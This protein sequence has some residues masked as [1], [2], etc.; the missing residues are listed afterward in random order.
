MAEFVGYLLVAAGGALGSVARYWLSQVVGRSFGET[1]PWGTVIVNISGSFIIGF[2]AAL[3]DPAG[4]RYLSPNSRLFFMYGICGGYTTFSSFSLQTFNLM[5]TGE[6]WKAGGNVAVS[7]FPCILATWFGYMLG[8]S[9]N[10][11]KG[12]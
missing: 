8:A 3:A 10:S 12:E 5:R 9:M 6:W 4:R 7:V 11:V 1:F 2:L